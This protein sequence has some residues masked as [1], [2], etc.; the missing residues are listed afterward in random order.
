MLIF[1]F[2]AAL[3]QHLVGILQVNF[4][5]LTRNWT[6]QTLL[7]PTMKFSRSL[8]PLWFCV[9]TATLIYLILKCD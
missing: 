6:V 9:K 7:S 5:L 3:F 1:W 2:H 8:I 4:K